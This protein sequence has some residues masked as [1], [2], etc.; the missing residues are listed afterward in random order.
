MLKTNKKILQADLDM[1]ANHA[2]LRLDM[3]E[4]A[5]THDALHAHTLSERIGKVLAMKEVKIDGDKPSV[6]DM[7]QNDMLFD[8]QAILGDE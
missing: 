4:A 2:Y 6:Y 1:S 5:L 3:K 7:G 8:L